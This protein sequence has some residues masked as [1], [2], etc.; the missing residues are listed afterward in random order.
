MQI[1]GTVYGKTSDGTRIDMVTVENSSGVSLSVISY[2]A[3]LVSFRA[4]GRDLPASEIT[5]GR[6]DLAAY[7]GGHPYFGSTV[8]RVANRISGASFSIDGTEYRVPANDGANCLH[9]GISAFDKKVWDIFPFREDSRAGV[10]LSLVS[11]DGDEGFPGKMEVSTVYTLTEDSELIL[12]YDAVCDRACPVN[13]T[14]HVYWNLNGDGSG[15]VLDHRLE[16][17]CSGV[18]PVSDILIPTGEILPVE[19]TPFDFRTEKEIG[20]DIGQVRGGYDHCWVTGSYNTEKD[21]KGSAETGIST[22]R[23]SAFAVLSSPATGRRLEF[24]TTQPG[25]QFYTGNF[26]EGEAGR[27]GIYSKHSGLCLETQNFPDSVNQPSF[28]DSVLRPGERYVHQT[29]IK[30]SVI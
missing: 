2:G 19:G 24:H 12:E 6:K 3:T 17:D 14:N 21:A 23:G 11:D 25:V 29:V 16:M 10:R 28:P 26:L 27:K 20:R 13:L 22:D 5:L 7:E 8:G 4:P 1:E 30:F 15:D 18:L 9:G